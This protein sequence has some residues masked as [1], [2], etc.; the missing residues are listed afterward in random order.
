MKH[1]RAIACCISKTRSSCVNRSNWLGIG[2][3]SM[4][5]LV[6]ARSVRQLIVCFLCMSLVGVVARAHAAPSG[7]EPARALLEAMARSESSAQRLDS[8]AKLAEIGPGAM[9]ELVAFLGR[10]RASSEVERRAILKAIGADIPDEKGRFRARKS[11]DKADTAEA[12]DWLAALVKLD[13]GMAG[14]GDVMADVAAIRALAA[15]KASAGAGAILDFGFTDAGLLY[16]DEC[17]RYLRKMSPYSL[18][19][20]IAASQDSS[21]KARAL[22]RYANYQLD[23]MD[24]EDPNKAIN[25]AGMD[26]G[27]MIEV[28]RAYGQSKHREAIVPLL[29]HTDDST[30]S[31]REA[32]REALLGYVTG[33]KPPEAPKR[34]LVLP[35]GKLSEEE[36]PLWLTYREL[37]DV[38]LRRKHEVVF[39]EQAPRK[40][41]PEELARKLF[42]HQDGLRERAFADAFEAT[43][44]LVEAGKWAEATQAFDRF[45]AARPDHP[46]RKDMAQAYFE[47]ARAQMQAGSFREASA[48]YSKAHGLDPEAPFAA[49]ALAGHYTALGK[50]LQAEGKDG[51]MAYRRAL[52]IKPTSRDAEAA[53]HHEMGQPRRAWMLY[54]GV[55]GGAGALILFI[56]G[57]AVR[58][59]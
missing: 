46:R 11:K 43:R 12:L 21:K 14:L 57:L 28:I 5:S 58:R 19:A 53:K 40:S 27:L 9:P 41:T 4:N 2:A 59:R 10:E 23:R 34:K 49:D 24:R 20:L 33:P 52:E 56:L 16:R 37:A 6:F 13:P 38:E 26:P 55:G 17:G 44:A 39:G 7:S 31:V 25:D 48:A 35:G 3:S 8:A 54:A 32:A 29:D 22:Q 42:A 36:Q 15:T 51:S 50:A 30:T 18:P 45:L 47:H 1:S